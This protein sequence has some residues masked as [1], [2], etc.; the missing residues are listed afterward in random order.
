[1]KSPNLNDPGEDSP[2]QELFVRVVLLLVF[3]GCCCVAPYQCLKFDPAYLIISRPP[4]ASM[5]Y[6][7]HEVEPT[8]Y[9]GE[10]LGTYRVVATFATGE[11]VTIDVYPRFGDD[12]SSSMVITPTGVEPHGDLKYKVISITKAKT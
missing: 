6:D 10:F 12:N 2:R 8:F 1:M 4:A 3:F 7:G 9:I 5:L 11:V